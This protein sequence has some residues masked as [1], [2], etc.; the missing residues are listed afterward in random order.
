MSGYYPGAIDLVTH[1][2][3]VPNLRTPGEHD[4]RTAD[5]FLADLGRET[6]ISLRLDPGRWPWR[7]VSKR[8]DP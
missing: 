1:A 5:Q 6:T 4:P 3:R 8:R 2:E 7:E